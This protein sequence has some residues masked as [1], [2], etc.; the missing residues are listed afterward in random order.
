M[1]TSMWA[2]VWTSVW[3]I[4]WTAMWTSMS[5]DGHLPNVAIYTTEQ[6][7]HSLH[8]LFYNTE[9]LA[10]IRRNLLFLQE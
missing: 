2:A 3:M 1:W 8:N 6:A 7:A 10:I 9:A 5:S 4:M